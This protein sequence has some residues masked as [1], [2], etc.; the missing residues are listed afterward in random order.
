MQRERA[1]SR[2][3]EVAPYLAVNL[4]HP[5]AFI[6]R[7]TSCSPAY[8]G[9]LAR[10]SPALKSR[11]HAWPSSAVSDIFS[12]LATSPCRAAR[13]RCAR[14]ASARRRR[15]AGETVEV[16]AQ[17]QI[18]VPQPQAGRASMRRLPCGQAK[19]PSPD[20]SA[21]WGGIYIVLLTTI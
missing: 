14:R 6:S 19:W 10:C 18:A 17:K 15:L 9:C 2:P 13:D 1:N 20:P 21:L 16:V 4:V 12:A 7:R 8:F 11:P 3:T 5:R